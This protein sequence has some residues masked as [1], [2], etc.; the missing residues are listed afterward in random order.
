MFRF[1]LLLIRQSGF[2]EARPAI[3]SVPVAERM[4]LLGRNPST[5][6]LIRARFQVMDAQYS[7]SK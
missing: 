4:A 7:S 1:A 2:P 5:W 6:E 3:Q